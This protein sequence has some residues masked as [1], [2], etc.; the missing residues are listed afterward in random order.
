MKNR[1]FSLLSFI[2]IAVLGMCTVSM[3]L[4]AEEQADVPKVYALKKVKVPQNAPA[5]NHKQFANGHAP[6]F[7]VYID[8]NGTNVGSVYTSTASWEIDFPSSKSNRWEVREG[9]GETYLIRLRDRNT[10]LYEHHVT[11]VGGITVE[12]FSQKIIREKVDEFAPQGS[13][14]EFHFELLKD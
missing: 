2:F 9:S 13:A 11:D 3:P 12:D 5:R 10:T 4:A 6:K 14:I 1:Y 7:R 8:R